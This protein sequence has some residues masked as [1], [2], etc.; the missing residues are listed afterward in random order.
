MMGR[1][2]FA[3]KIYYQLSLD[4]LVPK[5]HLLRRVTE[6]SDFSFIYQLARP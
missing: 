6:A 3:V 1:H 5:R 4:D 2:P